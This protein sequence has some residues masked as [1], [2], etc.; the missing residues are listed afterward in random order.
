MDLISENKCWPFDL[1]GGGGGRGWRYSLRFCAGRF[2]PKVQILTLNILIFIEIGNR[3]PSIYLEQKLHLFY[4][5]KKVKKLDNRCMLQARRLEAF[6]CICIVIST[7][8]SQIVL[9]LRPNCYLFQFKVYFG[10][11]LTY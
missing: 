7:K 4:P 8:I 10:D 1:C 11:S 3:T 2:L 5:S 6:V 9:V